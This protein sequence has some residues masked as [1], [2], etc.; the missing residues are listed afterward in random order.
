MNEGFG[1]CLERMFLH[2]SLHDI[3]SFIQEAQRPGTSIPAADAL[4]G[5]K[6]GWELP[7]SACMRRGVA[8]LTNVSTHRSDLDRAPG[9]R[10]LVHH[11][12][13][14]DVE[15]MPMRLKKYAGKI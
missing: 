7:S 11:Q 1:D 2:L 12:E 3:E 15:R 6:E 10:A 5:A 13:H 4:C 14:Q 9:S 8:R